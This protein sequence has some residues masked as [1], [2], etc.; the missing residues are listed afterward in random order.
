VPA[1]GK[2]VEGVLRRVAYTER[3]V[4]VIGPGA[5][6]P[7]TE[8]IV[9]VPAKARVTRDGKAI[10]FNDL[11]EDEKATVL[12]ERRDGRWVATALQAGTAPAAARPRQADLASRIR[13]ALWLADKV[14]RQMERKPNAGER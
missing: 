6:G 3:E 12:V 1:G 10:T 14:L 8:T 11:R 2:A 13:L 4:V 9:A 5:K 7:E